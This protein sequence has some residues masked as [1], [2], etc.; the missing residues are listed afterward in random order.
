MQS[1]C[2]NTRWEGTKMSQAPL[3][4]AQ[5][6]NRRKWVKIIILEIP[7]E[8]RKILF[9]LLFIPFIFM[10]LF[11]TV[12]VV[13]HW[14]RLPRVAL[15]PLSLEMLKTSLDMVLGSLL[16]LTLLELRCWNWMISGHFSQ[17][18]D[19]L[20][21]SSTPKWTLFGNNLHSVSIFP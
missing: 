2:T 20:S 8:C 7:S 9:I 12:R 18:N 13:S 3:S 1:V 11:I 4:S 14:N 15:E 5:W 19:S 17:I 6:Q 10:Y 16:Q 21:L